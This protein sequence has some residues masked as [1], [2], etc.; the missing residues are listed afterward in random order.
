M[1]AN[2]R[3]YALALAVGFLGVAN[4]VQGQAIPDEDIV[5][6]RTPGAR[7][8]DAGGEGAERSSGLLQAAFVKAQE[9]IPP[10]VMFFNVLKLFNDTDSAYSFTLQ[11]SLPDNGKL[12]AQESDLAPMTLM[13]GQ[14]HFV[15]IR[16]SFPAETQGGIP[17]PIT[18]SLA[19]PDG[20]PLTAPLK[21]AVSFTRHSK[22]RL[23]TPFAKAYTSDR[24]DVFTKA[25]VQIFNEGNV[26][27]Q[28]RIEFRAGDMLDLQETSSDVQVLEFVLPPLHDTALA[29][30][31]RCKPGDAGAKG[32]AYRLTITGRTGSDTVRQ[33]QTIQFEAI[34]A[35]YRNQISE[36]ES[37]LI[38][39]MAYT[40]G[41][42]SALVSLSGNVLLTEGRKFSYGYETRYAPA[43][44]GSADASDLFWRSARLYA[45]Y[46]NSQY[47]VR[48]GDVSLGGPAAFA[49]RGISF[50]QEK[51]QG[52]KLSLTYARSLRSP[53]WGLSGAYSRQLR[54][55]LQVKAG[56]SYVKRPDDQTQV[57]APSA[58]IRFSP[59]NT[60]QFA[61]DAGLTRLNTY[62]RGLRPIDQTGIGYKA[63]Y[64]GEFGRLTVSLKNQYG[65]KDYLGNGKGSFRFDAESGYQLRNESSLRL[66]YVY[67]RSQ[68][69]KTSEDGQ[70]RAYSRKTSQQA[71]AA[72]NL[73]LKTG[74]LAL[75]G[76][77]QQISQYSMSAERP[78]PEL[79]GVRRLKVSAATV[80]KGKQN[81]GL[82]L[83]PSAAL[84]VS[85]VYQGA[86][87]GETRL[88]AKAGL[89]ARLKY[90]SFSAEYLQQP[91]GPRQ[92]SE[93][94]APKTDQQ[95]RLGASYQR[96][97]LGDRLIIDASTAIDYLFAV[98]SMQAMTTAGVRY[99]GEYGWSFGADM[100]ADALRVAAGE[101]QPSVT[102]TARKVIEAPQPR[103]RYFNLKVVFFQ[104]EN[105]NRLR[106]PEETGIGNVLVKLERAQDPPPSG[107]AEP[108]RFKPP[109]IMS[110]E[111]GL[112]AFLK[113]PE[114]TY[115]IKLKE[116]FP[117]MLYT[118]LNGSELEVLLNK[119]TTLLVPYTKSVM[120]T[121]KIE[122]ARDKYSRLT[123]ITPARIRVTVTDANGGVYH[124][125]SDDRGNFIISAPF[126][127]RYTVSIKN[128]LG[129]KFDLPDGTQEVE[130]Q[131][132]QR[133]EVNFHFKEKGRTINFGTGG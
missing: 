11:F 71:T 45:S 14:S 75:A 80:I 101:G 40:P 73:K 74:A 39:S 50:T 44:P 21:T 37:P 15:P 76:S 7:A 111:T 72:L 113:S 131:G 90:A 117:Q 110:D 29:V 51:I 100:Q 120:I 103:L 17:F 22:W 38:I 98:K 89:S 91:A 130:T 83:V 60:Q 133:V 31:V 32:L 105:G 57:T 28:L 126:T 16:V 52:N 42:G 47:K 35:D 85:S 64:S 34:A 25:P 58:G 119:H 127:E 125:L 106:E 12:F 56:L 5:P 128:V 59:S 95:F 132:Q 124:S 84:G 81:S 30:H 68:N 18:V 115:F 118:N 122:I 94:P 108:V 8:D 79:Y 102:L 114:G 123:G 104:D 24:K 23:F 53:E 97:F 10:G 6:S 49:G 77:Y 48:L 13:P 82:S 2:I 65:S 43:A 107:T 41:S 93:Q 33:V 70:L 46:E 99:Q 36:E 66:I 129:D 116:L 87:A 62:G 26:A 69:E 55:G 27:E 86:G 88:L 61:L 109:E 1:R 19:G 96:S 121:G 112:A 67:T 92:P 9:E 4:S 78:D 63:S 3:I 20:K 54:Q